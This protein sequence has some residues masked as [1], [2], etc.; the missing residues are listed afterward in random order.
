MSRNENALEFSEHCIQQLIK[1]RERVIKNSFSAGG[2]PKPRLK[3]QNV[4]SVDQLGF[5]CER[6]AK[7]QQVSVASNGT[8]S[9]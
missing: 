9:T 4:L 8:D 2:V 7:A 3:A 5:A 1:R 6:A